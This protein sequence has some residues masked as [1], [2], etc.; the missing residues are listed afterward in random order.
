MRFTLV[1]AWQFVVISHNREG[2]S[3]RQHHLT[4]YYMFAFVVFTSIGMFYVVL[5][6]PTTHANLAPNDPFDRVPTA[7]L[8]GARLLRFTSVHTHLH[9]Q[10]RT[11]RPRHTP[12]NCVLHPL[13]GLV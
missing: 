7:Y 9:P 2:E 4:P 6:Q 8:G 11:T 5:T 1:A 3:K 10:H 13:P 12:D